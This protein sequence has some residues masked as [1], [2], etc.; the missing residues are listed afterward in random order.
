M[1]NDLSKIFENLNCDNLQ[2]WLQKITKFHEGFSNYELLRQV[3][4]GQESTNFNSVDDL[5][6][7][8]TE[9][10]H[11]SHEF[12]DISSIIK[13][14]MKLLKCSET[15]Q[16][17]VKLKQLKKIESIQQPTDDTKQMA[18]QIQEYSE[19][20]EKLRTVAGLEPK[21]NHLMVLKW[22]HKYFEKYTNKNIC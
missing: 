2:K 8:V 13:Y 9:A 16:L 21:Y 19:I 12:E 6:R 10:F 3:I 1:Q 22:V 5:C 20:I 18:D 15:N 7:C 4:N 11:K 14:C 17:I